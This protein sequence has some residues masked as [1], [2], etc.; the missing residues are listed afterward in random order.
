MTNRTDIELQPYCYRCGAPFHGSE[1]ELDTW[2][3]HTVTFGAETFPAAIYCPACTTGREY[4]EMEMRD[5]LG[6]SP[7]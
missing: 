1:E 7:Q 5:A 2:G 4:T 6:D 3:F